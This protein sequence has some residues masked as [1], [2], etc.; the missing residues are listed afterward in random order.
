MILQEHPLRLVYLFPLAL[1]GI[2]F[3]AAGFEGYLVKVGKL[4]QWVRPLLIIAGAL[5]AFPTSVSWE[6]TAIGAILV[7]I[8]IAIIRSRKKVTPEKSL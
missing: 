6:T 2:V 8:V 1:I 3:I 4:E 5:I 7:A